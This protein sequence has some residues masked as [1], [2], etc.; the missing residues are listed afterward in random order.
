[1]SAF[2]T[3]YDQ[4]QVHLPSIALAFCFYLILRLLTEWRLLHIFDQEVG[5][6]SDDLK[7]GVTVRIGFVIALLNTFS[8]SRFRFYERLL[9]WLLGTPDQKLTLEESRALVG[10]L[11]FNPGKEKVVIGQ[12]LAFLQ[13][14]ILTELLYR[15]PLLLFPELSFWAWIAVAA[16]AAG[17]GWVHWHRNAGFTTDIVLSY[18]DGQP[19]EI[20]TRKRLRAALYTFALALLCGTG[21]IYFLSIWVAVLIHAFWNINSSFWHQRAMR[22]YMGKLAT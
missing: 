18:L 4:V 19:S 21:A 5:M 6:I 14:P 17:F 20:P 9:D 11:V 12:V 15:A 16:A 13:L 7:G 10:G 8:L 22:Q 2:L 1:M 3:V